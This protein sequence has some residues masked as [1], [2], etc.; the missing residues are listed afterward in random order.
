MDEIQ[1]S[2]LSGMIDFLFFII[3][4]QTLFEISK[5]YENKG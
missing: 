3:L 4:S 5:Y 1:T 2:C